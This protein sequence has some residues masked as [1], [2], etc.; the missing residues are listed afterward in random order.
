MSLTSKSLETDDFSTI[1]NDVFRL[2]RK[3]D[4]YNAYSSMKI[5]GCGAAFISK[6]LYFSALG[7]NVFPLPVILDGRV[8][9]SLIKIGIHEGWLAKEFAD[10]TINSSGNVFVEKNA[11]K[12][13]EY[14]KQM[15]LWAKALGCP[16][17]YI[18]YYLWSIG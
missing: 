7:G 6:F 17:D 3:G 10:F 13:V 4:I 15:D 2:V 18:E 5:K 1:I 16:A 8:M 11:T 14:I 9:N 12:Y